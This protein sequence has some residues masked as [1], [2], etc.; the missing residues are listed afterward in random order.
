ME[1]NEKKK[2]IILA[3]I[4]ILVLIVGIVGLTY[5]Y[6]IA[7]GQSEDITVTSKNLKIV[8]DDNT[9]VINAT[10][11]EPIEEAEILSKATKKT[12]SIAKESSE[13]K[14]LYVRLDM[15]DLVIS[16]NF[17]D[18][19]FKWALYQ[20]TN[21]ITTGT[22]VP[23]LDGST[24]IN[25]ATNIL[26][27]S[28][29]PIEYN[30][31][32]WINETGLDQSNLM[33][34]RL[35]G[36]ITAVGE[37]KQLNTL[38]SNI[39]KE[40]ENLVEEFPL[41][42]SATIESQNTEKSIKSGTTGRAMATEYT[43]DSKTGN[44]DLS[45]NIIVTQFSSEYLNY[46]TCGSIPRPCRYLYKIRA[47]NGTEVTHVD[48]YSSTIKN[49]G[50]YVQKDDNERSEFGFPTYYY[51]GST[52]SDTINPDYTMNN[53]VKLGT[54]K[55]NITNNIYNGSSFEDKIVASTNDSILWR[56]VRINE[57]GSI[58]LIAEDSINS[59]YTKEQLDTKFLY[60]N[61]D[62]TDSE[63]KQDIDKWYKT[64]ITENNL[65]NKI[66]TSTF[67]NDISGK[68]RKRI[69]DNGHIRNTC[70]KNNT[71]EPY[72]FKCSNGSI[73]ANEKAGMITADELV[74]S[75]AFYDYP[76][77]N[78]ISYLNNSTSF[79]TITPFNI[80]Y[81][82]FSWKTNR[83]YLS[84]PNDNS[85]FSLRTVINLKSD[86]LVSGGT[87]SKNDPYIIKLN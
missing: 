6:F 53:Y 19:D 68:A 70:I 41:P 67:C 35:T 51:R 58:K 16:E 46:Y 28:T 76:L 42:L 78:N 52:T 45:G 9:P 11:I 40:N 64:N 21:K 23:T 2:K 10:D 81:Y 48:V 5:A 1:N 7:R 38:A 72:S 32:I 8:F 74:Y 66:Q 31:Y 18:F 43:V 36:K 84:Y 77:T 39:L 49:R 65:D 85:L 59:G 37:A 30:L 63:I 13:G 83:M 86:T 33:D 57:D 20:G 75:G 69:I 24:S 25:M 26:L 50:L 87:G 29:T 3:I 4:G 56:I 14:D 71:C 79:L 61:E 82:L 47:V 22:F 44:F 62:G 60:V 27:N 34:G 55:N 80:N 54:Y 73:I 17:K 12:F 15:T